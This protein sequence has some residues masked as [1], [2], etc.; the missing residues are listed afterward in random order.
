MKFR[1]RLTLLFGGLLAISL[2]TVLLSIDRIAKSSALASIE[3][4]LSNT[5]KTVEKLHHQRVHNLQQNLRLLA[6]DYGFKS[7]Y[8]SEDEPTIRSALENHQNRLLDANLMVLCDLDGMVLS[9]TYK[10]MLNGIDFPWLEVLEQ[11]DESESGEATALGVLDDIVYQFIVTPLLAPDIE[12]WVV[13]GFRLDKATAEQLSGITGSEVS[14][15]LGSG[16][17]IKMIASTLNQ[18][19][20][21]TLLSFLQDTDNRDNSDIKLK[22][23]QAENETHI[24]QLLALNNPASPRI[25]AFVQQSLDNA[26]E[27]YHKLSRRVSWIFLGSVAS[28][29]LLIIMLSKTVTRS[30]TNLSHAARAIAMGKL[31]TRVEDKG[32]DEF[33]LLSRTFNEMTQGLAEKEQVRDLLGKVVSPEIASKLISEGVELGGEEREVTVLFCDIQGFTQLS[34]SQAPTQV[35][36]ALNQFFTGVSDIIEAHGGVVDKYIGDAVMAL[37]GVPMDDQQHAE[38]AVTCGIKICQAADELISMLKSSDGRYC[39][40]GVGIHTGSV[41]AGNVGSS[42]RL[43]YTV[44]GDTVNVASRVEGQSRIFDTPLI[45]TDVT[46]QQCKNITFIELGCVKLKGRTTAINLLTVPGLDNL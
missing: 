40:F 15:L 24:G 11:A 30:L 4:N 16:Q 1:T 2:A 5:V 37:F 35:L 18:P 12:A 31:D 41:V 43:N 6:G 14:F 32:N 38:N 22:K 8:A 23:Y 42:T 26:L 29:L 3:N 39:S 33:G 34:E 20:Q 36:N 25:T 17:G 27:P 19:T 45:V 46:A 7:A 21:K 44:I 9:N 28:V 10:M 13:S